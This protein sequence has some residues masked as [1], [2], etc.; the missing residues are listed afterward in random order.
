MKRKFNNNSK[1]INLQIQS[2]LLGA[3]DNSDYVNSPKATSVRASL[4]IIVNEFNNWLNPYQRR[5]SATLQKAFYDFLMCVPGCIYVTI[6]NNEAIELMNQWRV[7]YPDTS[8]D[9]TEAVALFYALIFRNFEKL[10]NMYE[11]DFS[12]TSATA[13]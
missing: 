4:T 13:K 11:V 5:Q 9:D 6:W 1:Q 8:E 12:L 3:I 10:C 2:Y 7:V